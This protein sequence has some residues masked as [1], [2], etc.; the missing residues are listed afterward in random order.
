MDLPEFEAWLDGFINVKRHPERN[1]PTMQILCDYFGHPESFCPC[2]HVAGSKGKGTITAN[3]AAILRAAGYKTGCYMSPHV[4]HFSERIGTGAGDFSKG[5][6]DAAFRQLKLGIDDL[7]SQNQLAKDQLAWTQLVTI[8]AMLCFRIEK[9]DFAIY[10]VGMGG[11]YDSTN[12]ITPVCC[13]FG[14]IELEHT[15]I[16][17]DNLYD[18]AKEK[19]G[20]IKYQVPAIS[21]PQSPEVKK[22]F[23]ETAKAQSTQVEY[24]RQSIENY[25]RQDAEIAKR[26]VKKYL[27]N[28]SN[29]LINQALQNVFLPGRFEIIKN[30]PNYPDIPYVLIDVAHTP[31]SISQVISRIKK[32][33]L[34]GNL[35]FGCAADK[36]VEAIAKSIIKSNLF[37]NIYLTR[38]SDYKKS[39]INQMTQ[40]F[41]KAYQ[42][43]SKSKSRKPTK[44]TISTNPNFTTFIPE[45]LSIC[46]STRTPLI[47]L[48]S[49]Y[50]A[51]EVKK[52]L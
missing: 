2:F 14:P 31:N 18:I 16:L 38:P 8:F 1:L 23:A 3:I 45:V 12:I 37:Q 5:T 11:R 26:A 33:K 32:E 20:I 9:V 6:Y 24:L 40:A 47:V 51:G 19:A 48:G 22:A 7:I 10:E 29:D 25:Q 52:V 36:N 50:L 35:L 28:I 17:G 42:D 43:N 21:A 30:I 15:K 39:D 44:P 41:Q 46:N 13:C 27:P 4:S 34:T 49:F